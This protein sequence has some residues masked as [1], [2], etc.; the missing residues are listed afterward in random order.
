[1]T[2]YCF[3]GLGENFSFGVYSLFMLLLH[4]QEVIMKIKP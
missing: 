2:A 4:L 3:W 1:M